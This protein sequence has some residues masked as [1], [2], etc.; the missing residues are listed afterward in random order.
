MK[1]NRDGIDGGID[2]DHEKEEDCTILHTRDVSLLS[3]LSSYDNDDYHYHHNHQQQQ[4]QHHKGRASPLRNPIHASSLIAS[5]D[6]PHLDIVRRKNRLSSSSS[7]SFV[8]S[9]CR[10]NIV[11]RRISA[12]TLL[13]KKDNSDENVKENAIAMTR[14]TVPTSSTSTSSPSSY[15]RVR[16]VG[17]PSSFDEEDDYDDT[18]SLCSVPHLMRTCD[19]QDY[20]EDND[21]GN[22]DIDSN[23]HGGHNDNDQ[24]L[25]DLI[26]MRKLM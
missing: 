6:L 17:Q 15:P 13:K 1:M 10:N 18:A 9:K 20:E 2:G 25:L 23:L 8:D 21:D 7:S 22:Y 12:S 5:L 11:H 4:Q 16:P 26:T 14:T 24:R 3:S 19:S